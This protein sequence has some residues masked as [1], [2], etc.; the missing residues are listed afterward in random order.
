MTELVNSHTEGTDCPGSFDA[1]E[2]YTMH[3]ESGFIRA[4]Y[5]ALHILMLERKK[6]WFDMHG[7][8]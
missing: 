7:K 4:R 6:T 3:V 2:S 5:N 8:I 1:R